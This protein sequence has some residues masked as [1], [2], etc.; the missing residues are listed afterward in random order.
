M[1]QIRL[2]SQHYA[3]TWTAPGPDGF[4]DVSE[5]NK[6]GDTYA[7]LPDGPEKEARLLELI[8]SF[9][10]YLSK[11]LNMIMRGHIAHFCGRMNTD[12]AA[13]LKYMIGKNTKIDNKS[14]HEAAKFLHIAFKQQDSNDIYDTLVTCL[15]RAIHKYDPYYTDKL[16]R[17][18]EVISATKQGEIIVV[19]ELKSKLDFDCT[20]PLRL[21]VSHG[22][23]TTEKVDKKVLGYKRLVGWPPP[24]DKFGVDRIGF[25][26]FVQKWFRYY[27]QAYIE[28]STEELEAKAKGDPNIEGFALMQLEHRSASITDCSNLD[29]YGGDSADMLPHRHGNFSDASGAGWAIDDSLV[30]NSGDVSHLDLDWVRKT[31]DPL[32]RDLSSV[33]RFILYQHFAKELSW[34]EIARSLQM[35]EKDVHEHY[36]HILDYLRTRAE[37]PVAPPKKCNRKKVKP[38]PITRDLGIQTC[39]QA[40]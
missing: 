13:F 38:L 18:I 24:A 34:E 36:E 16:R 3:S 7:R 6:Q 4:Y 19:A 8:K 20:G 32:F 35:S 5:V 29:S 37:S 27:L 28:R 11:Y 30:N 40:L 15:L 31:K 26:Y 12:S 23:L 10:T 22:F 1:R 21:L 14:L 39:V 9:H 33:E 2:D 25:T 17:L